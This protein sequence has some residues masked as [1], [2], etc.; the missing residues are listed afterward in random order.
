MPEMKKT[1][2]LA[3]EGAT[4]VL[5]ILLAFW[6]D[7]TWAAQ[8]D[9]ARERDAIQALYEEAVANA[10][11]VANV[12]EAVR[13]Y[14]AEALAFFESRGNPS[15]VPAQEVDE[16]IRSLTIPNRA[17]LQNGSLNSL[18]AS[19]GIVLIR[20][21]KLQEALANWS[22]QAARLDARSDLLVQLE[23]EM[24]RGLGRHGDIQAW[25][26]GSR[27]AASVDFG[28]LHEDSELMAVLSAMQRER[29]IYVSLLGRL[30]AQLSD[31]IAALEAARA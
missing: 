22:E 9:R 26:I 23:V 14:S 27:A 17:S 13:Q 4:I 11:Q 20:D 16:L 1:A 28:A 29:T 19:G 10:D 15:A 24:L 25:L 6:I 30:S 5:S 12:I 8:L 3:S 31:L 21:P 7:A 18:L 2:R